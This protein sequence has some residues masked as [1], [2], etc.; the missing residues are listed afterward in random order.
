[1]VL[2]IKS[3]PLNRRGWGALTVVIAGLMQGSGILADEVD[4]K[5]RP[6]EWPT[7]FAVLASS[8]S[9]LLFR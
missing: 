9:A 2:N 6:G 7:F 8:D 3:L 1:M 4:E 5:P